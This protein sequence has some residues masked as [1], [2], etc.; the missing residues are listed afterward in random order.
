MRSLFLIIGLCLTAGLW[1]QR[2][3]VY[4]SFPRA[5]ATGL[6]CDVAI[7]LKMQ[8]P[9]EARILDPI[10]LSEDA[11]WLSTQV[12]KRVPATLTYDE[13]LHTLTLWPRVALAPGEVY[14]FTLTDRL[15]DE[16]GFAFLPYEMHFA[17]GDCRQPS[18]DPLLPT[19]PADSLPRTR[20]RTFDAR[21]RGDSLLLYWAVEQEYFTIS[22]HLERAPAREGPY[23][24]VMVVPSLGDTDS[25]RQYAW[26][27]PKPGQGAVYYRL[28]REGLLDSLHYLDTLARFRSHI[29]LVAEDIPRGDSLAIECVMPTASTM[30]LILKDASGRIRRRKAGPLR[31]GHQLIKIPLNGL[32]P[33]P[34]LVLLRTP[35][36]DLT[37][38][39]RIY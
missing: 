9:S 11:V 28:G 13:A 21:W 5:G 36:K 16:R 34:Y 24:P 38:P 29:R 26:L 25:L 33:G 18:A 12:G 35:E 10:T 7:R 6:G 3:Y 4:G 15:V 23:V 14:T 32:P 2:P 39:I 17:T 8:F 19:P 30:A 37:Q 20:L 27:D 31:P 22:Y 1:A